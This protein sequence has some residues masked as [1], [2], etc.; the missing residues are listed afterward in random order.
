MSFVGANQK[1]SRALTP[2][3]IKASGVFDMFPKLAA[4]LFAL[5]STRRVVD[6]GAGAAWCFPIEYKSYFDLTLIGIDIDAD[7]MVLNP[8]LDERIVG[9]VCASLNIENGTADLITAYSGVEHFPDNA[10]FLRNCHKALRPGGRWIGQFPSRYA[11]F[12]I[13]NRLIPEAP[14]KRLLG[15]LRPDA[16]DHMGFKA[17]YDRTHYSAFRKMAEEAGFVVE[18]WHPGYFHFYFAFFTPLYLLSLFSGLVRMAFGVRDFATYNLFILR[19]PGPA[20]VVVLGKER[21]GGTERAAA[22]AAALEPA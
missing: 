16:A 17:F 5:P 8:A 20:E 22:P 10:A 3:A 21:H 7:E 4:V 15:L 12:A 2:T 14:K 13:L 11:S 9:N 19:K 1:L 6:A 18:Y